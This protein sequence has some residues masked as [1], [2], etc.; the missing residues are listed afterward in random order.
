[1]GIEE[2]ASPDDADI[3]EKIVADELGIE[4]VVD[5]FE[6]PKNKGTVGDGPIFGHTALIK[7]SSARVFRE[8]LTEG[9]TGDIQVD[10]K[11]PDTC[12]TLQELSSRICNGTSMVCKV[13]I[14]LMQSAE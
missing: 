3:A 5:L 10:I 4:A 2:L 11:N 7:V 12:V 13:L 6:M 8:L 14:E 9:H 1:M